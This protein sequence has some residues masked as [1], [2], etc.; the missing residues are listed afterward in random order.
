MK[1]AILYLQTPSSQIILLSFFFRWRF[2]QILVKNKH[3][4]ALKVENFQVKSIRSITLIHRRLLL[5]PVGSDEQILISC[6]QQNAA[7]GS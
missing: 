6:W 1:P 2:I 7:T 4:L 5:T 3:S